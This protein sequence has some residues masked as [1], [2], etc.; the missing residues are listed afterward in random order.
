MGSYKGSAENELVRKYIVFYAPQLNVRFYVLRLICE[1]ITAHMEVEKG[2][3]WNTIS[4]P[5]IVIITIY[6]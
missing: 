4:Q 5:F 2:S 1:A 3:I 6:K